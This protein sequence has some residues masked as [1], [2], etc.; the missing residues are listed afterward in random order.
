MVVLYAAL[1]LLLAFLFTRLSA[2]VEVAAVPT[3]SASSAAIADI[4]GIT[5]S[6]NVV[7]K[8]SSLFALDSFAGGFVVQSFA[9]YWF[10][11][12]FGVEPATPGGHFLLGECFCRDFRAGGFPSCGAD[13]SGPDDG[14]HASAFEHSSHSCAVDAQSLARG[15]SASSAFQHQPDGRPGEAVLY[16]GGGSAGRTLRCRRFHGSRTDNRCGD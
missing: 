9:A 15:P 2:L 3:R 14:L 16:H 5:R 8:L 11:L 12:R 1:G 13:W 7:L 10:Y 4:F 6:R